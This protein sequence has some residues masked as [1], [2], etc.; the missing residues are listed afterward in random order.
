MKR[1]FFKVAYC[2]MERLLVVVVDDR[3]AQHRAA[4]GP[5]EARRASP[6]EPMCLELIRLPI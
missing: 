1:Q 6:C 5:R 3:E 4:K 2:K